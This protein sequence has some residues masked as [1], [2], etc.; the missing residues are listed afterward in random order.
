MSDNG[1]KPGYGGEHLRL[2]VVVMAWLEALGYDVRFLPQEAGGFDDL[3]ARLE[4]GSIQQQ[5]LVRCLAG[6]ILPHDVDEFAGVLT[7]ETPQGWLLGAGPMSDRVY[8]R[9][10]PIDALQVFT[11]PEFLRKHI[12]EPYI[13]W[14]SSLMEQQGIARSY[15]APAIQAIESGGRP[16]EVGPADSLDTLV[17]AWLRDQDSNELLVVVGE[18]GSGKTRFCLHYA[19]TQMQRFLANP[20]RERMPLYVPMAGFSQEAA[21]FPAIYHQLV[22]EYRLPFVGGSEIVREM[23]RR[24]LLLL[25]L[26]GFRQGAVGPGQQAPGEDPLAEAGS[27]RGKAILCR[28]AEDPRRTQQP[29]AQIVLGA[30]PA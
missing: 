30:P 21:V 17:D 11:L 16:G 22:A 28:R 4:R 3:L 6:E 7:R 25:I 24:G 26:D 18:P 8:M 27:G 29:F 2:A 14:L 9:A 19:A 5:V 10:A 1:T 13:V 23:H 15:Q 20:L 12:W